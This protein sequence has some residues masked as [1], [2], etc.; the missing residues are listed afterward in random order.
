MENIAVFAPI[1]RASERIATMLTS[2]VRRR[3]R[4][5][6][7]R[8]CTGGFDGGDCGLDAVRR[9]MVA[10]VAGLVASAVMATRRSRRAIRDKRTLREWGGYRG[11]PDL[12]DR[13]PGIV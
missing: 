5:A 3:A 8:L 10:R 12:S 6:S 1:P 13:G 9:R 11:L 7:R 2:G 4:Q